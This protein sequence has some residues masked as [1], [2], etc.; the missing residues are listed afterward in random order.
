MPGTIRGVGAQ[1]HAGICRRSC[2]QTCVGLWAGILHLCSRDTFASLV[3]LYADFKWRPSSI[4]LC[5]S[6]SAQVRVRRSARLTGMR[7]IGT[8]RTG[9]RRTTYRKLRS[10]GTPKPRFWETPRHGRSGHSARRR[11]T[12]LVRRSRPTR[13]R[14]GSPSQAKDS[15]DRQKSLGSRETSSPEPSGRDGHRGANGPGAI[16]LTPPERP[17]EYQ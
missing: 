8:V 16:R 10:Y 4:S 1:H 6:Q 15:K 7:R 12:A 13:R 17:R 14:A 11:S 9:T 5:R 3:S 2:W